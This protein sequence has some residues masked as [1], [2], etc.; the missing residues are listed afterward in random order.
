VVIIASAIASVY[1]VYSVALIH[2]PR[3]TITAWFAIHGHRL[4]TE[5]E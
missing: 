1:R 3:E 4:F 5:L 2:A